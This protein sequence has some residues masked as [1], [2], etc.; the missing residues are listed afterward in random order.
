MTISYQDVPASTMLEETEQRQMYFRQK[1]EK[2]QKYIYLHP[3]DKDYILFW[4]DR[5]VCDI[6]AMQ[7]IDPTFCQVLFKQCKSMP[8]S[9]YSKLRNTP[10]TFAAGLI[11]NARRNP[12]EDFAKKQIKYITTLF[13]IIHFAYT[14]GELKK[15]L[16]YNVFTGKPNDIPYNLVF[17]EA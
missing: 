4:A 16:G 6:I 7:I 8:L 2:Q 14:E 13:K 10:I 11:S 5:L 9:G 1:I 3:E 12:K 15:E 17:K